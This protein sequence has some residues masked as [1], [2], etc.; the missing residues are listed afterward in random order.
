[1]SYSQSILWINRE[2]RL[3]LANFTPN[4]LV[5]AIVAHFLC[6]VAKFPP[7]TTTVRGTS[8][9]EFPEK[10]KLTEREK[11]HDDRRLSERCRKNI[12]HEN[13]EHIGSPISMLVV[14]RRLTDLSDLVKDLLTALGL[15][16]LWYLGARQ[17]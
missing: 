11:E 1:M 16:G 3:S 17:L 15:R 14:T 10:L 4:P 13:R 9:P 8:L 6:A 2:N 7:P 5:L 12:L